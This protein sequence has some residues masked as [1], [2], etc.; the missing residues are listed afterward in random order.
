ML[1]SLELVEIERARQRDP[2][3]LEI[4]PD[5]GAILYYSRQYDRAIEQFRTVLEIDPTFP[6]ARLIYVAYAESGSFTEALASIEKWRTDGDTPWIRATPAYVYGKSGRQGGARLAL[7]KLQQESVDPCEVDVPVYVVAHL[8][9]NEKD[10]VITCLQAARTK[11]S[12]ALTTLKVDPIFDPLRS[13]LRCQ[14]LLRGLQ[15]TP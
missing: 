8:G 11:H 9:V 7:Q 3:S 14:D 12:D 4:A 13:D 5:K 15:T 10:K 1:I 2:L 6:R